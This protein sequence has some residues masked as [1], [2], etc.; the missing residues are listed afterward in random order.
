LTGIRTASKKFRYFILAVSAPKPDIQ[1]FLQIEID[2]AVIAR[3]HAL[4]ALQHYRD[5]LTNQETKVRRL[6]E[7][8]A[9][10]EEEYTVSEVL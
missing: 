6:T 8:Q 5:K 7:K 3:T 2:E 10:E 1:L 4:A 9:L